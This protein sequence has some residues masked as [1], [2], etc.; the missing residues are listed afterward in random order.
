MLLKIWLLSSHARITQAAAAVNSQS[1]LGAFCSAP[2]Q[3]PPLFPLRDRARRLHRQKYATSGRLRRSRRNR[4][5][6][7]KRTLPRIYVD[8]GRFR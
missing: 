4:D 2:Q 8:G 5:G 7:A 6:C 1:R 3:Y